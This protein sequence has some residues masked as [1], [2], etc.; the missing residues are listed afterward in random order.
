VITFLFDA[1]ESVLYG[2]QLVEDRRRMA[3]YVFRAQAKGYRAIG[4]VRWGTLEFSVEF[5]DDSMPET[6]Y[7]Y[8]TAASGPVSA[9]MWAT[10][11]VLVESLCT[12]NPR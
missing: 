1:L 11:D 8:Y 7:Y 4:S 10:I 6:P 12:V 3:S 2:K 5:S 9:S